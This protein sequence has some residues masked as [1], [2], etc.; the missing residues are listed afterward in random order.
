MHKNHPRG[1]FCFVRVP[2]RSPQDQY[3]FSIFSKQSFSKIWKKLFES[4]AR[5][6]QM[7]RSAHKIR[8]TADIWCACQDSNLGPPRYKLGAL[9]TELHAQ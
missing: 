3:S 5:S 2:A 9:P 6:M 4:W 8:L 7:L 1:D